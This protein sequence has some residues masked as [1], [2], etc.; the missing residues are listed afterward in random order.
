MQ[1]FLSTV[2]SWK[3]SPISL[4]RVIK[5]WGSAPR[6]PGSLMFVNQDG[7][8]AGSVSGGCVEGA[9]V[10][11]SL[12]LIEKQAGK[13]LDYGV[14]DEDAWSVGLS[15]GGRIQVFLQPFDSHN[16]VWSAL[17]GH[18][19]KNTSAIL[20]TSLVNGDF[21]NSLLT[22]E[23]ELVGD[24]ISDILKQKALKAYDARQHATYEEDGIDY[25]IQLFPR[26][27][28][29]VIIGVAHITVDLITLGKMYGF[30]TIVIDPRGYFA[31]KTAF[32]TA[33]DQLYQDYP[34]EVLPG[35]TLD[36]YTFCAILSHDPKID[37]NALEVLLPLEKIGYIGALG[38]RKTHEKRTAR[39]KD[40]GMSDELINK[41]HAPI[42]LRIGAK[43]AREIALAVMGEIIQAKN[44]FA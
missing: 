2:N 9:V 40:K 26:K 36:A 18:L 30:E 27:P 24:E 21:S 11:E 25:F 12:A 8:M 6:Q 23:G 37:D 34:S 35:I 41:I 29:L 31:E 42:G 5:T 17:I 39:L 32:D 44:Q 15:C 19:Q 33:P 14:S 10:K 16:E 20:V 13:K 7:E 28:Q 43:G 38:S 3:N 4:A 1:E 22:P